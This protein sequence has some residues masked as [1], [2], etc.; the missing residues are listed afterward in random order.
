ME[1]S[2]NLTTER[3]VVIQSTAE[4]IWDVLT[5]PDKINIYLFGSQAITD[6]K[7][8]SPLIFQRE[9]QGYLYRDKGTVLEFAPC[10]KLKFSYWSSQEGYPDISENYSIITYTLGHEKTGIKLTYRRENI[11]IELE[12]IN[13]E[14]FLP[15]MLDNI[16]KLAENDALNRK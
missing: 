8:G 2:Q 7:V 16:K 1:K 10:K 5:N 6:W 11:P 9:S 4:S 3:W 12:R 15:G 13:Q 14:R